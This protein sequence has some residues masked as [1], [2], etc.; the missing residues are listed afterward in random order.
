[1]IKIKKQM[2]KPYCPVQALLPCVSISVY[3]KYLS[4]KRF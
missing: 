2:Y 3:K 4:L 1:M